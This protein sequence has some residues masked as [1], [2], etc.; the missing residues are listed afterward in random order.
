M[1][2]PIVFFQY[3]CLFSE[4]VCACSCFLLSC[5]PEH[6]QTLVDAETRSAVRL[7]KSQYCK[8]TSLLSFYRMN[9]FPCRW[10]IRIPQT[11]IQAVRRLNVQ[12]VC[13]STT[14]QTYTLPPLIYKQ[15]TKSRLRAGRPSIRCFDSQ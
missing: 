2:I 4:Y 8:Q 10:L 3:V 12:N 1:L 7:Q 6:K 11:R 15:S 14:S 9:Y 5:L 13:Y